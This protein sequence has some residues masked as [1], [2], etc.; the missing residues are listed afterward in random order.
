M[1]FLS[2]PFEFCESSL[3]FVAAMYFFSTFLPLILL[4]TPVQSASDSIRRHYEAAESHSR[5]GNL[6][7]A[8]AEYTAILAEAHH[9]LGRIQIARAEYSQAVATLQ[10]AASY[11]SD[12]TEVLVDLAIA[13]FH[14]EKY[15]R[16][17]DPLTAALARDGRN[18]PAHHMMG[19]THFMLGDFEGSARS[20]EAG[21]KL[22]PDDYDI[23]YTLGLAYLKQGQLPPAVKLYSR[24]IARLGD[25]P[26]LRVLIGRAYRETGYLGEAIEEFKRAIALDP[27]FPRVHYYLGLT[28]LLKD[29]AGR[30]GDAAAQFEIELAAHPDEYLA[31]YYLG[32]VNTIERN[33]DKALGF[34]NKAAQIQPA[35]P[36]P[37]FYLGQAFQSL[38]NYPQ[39]IEN[40]RKSIA[41]NPSLRHN[42]NQVTNAHYRLGQ[43]LLKVG[44]VAE[45]ERE[46]QLAAELKSKAFKRDEAK[47]ESFLNAAKLSEANKTSEL[48]SPGGVLAET[49]APDAQASEKLK[50]EAALYAKVIATAH[51]NIGLLRADLK[52]FRGAAAQFSRVAKL[53][54]EQ[55]D[56]D[57]NLGLAHFKSESFKDAVPPLENVLK[58]QPTNISAKHLL[59]MSYFMME[60]YTG[61]AKMLSDVIAAKPNE[62][63]LYFPLALSLGKLGKTEDAS[64]VT[65]QM[66]AI[67]GDSPQLR[68]M[69]GQAYYEQGQSAKALEELKAAVKLNSTVRLAHFY[70]G[71][72]YLKTGKFDEAIQE[73]ESELALNPADLQAK[74]HLGYVFLARQDPQRGIKLMREVIDAKPDFGNARFELG[75]AL[76][77]QGDIK[78]AVESLE[79]A[80]KLEPNQSHVHYQLGR[81]Y[82][83]AGRRTEGEREIEISK[84]IKEKARTQANP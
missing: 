12:S 36:D 74:Y 56:L 76:L 19:K 71:V 82:I 7:A 49:Y 52:D 27:R 54:P 25:R 53:N 59:G 3:E 84:G 47:T 70:A 46:L 5:A 73:F 8:E 26:Q 24:M 57:Y 20:L 31:N 34:M 48:V 66:M 68:I 43:S 33:W 9:R 51:N 38:E 75:K 50:T 23:A 81:A 32:I 42:D 63:A 10:T 18:V 13:Y 6:T 77:Q 16:A 55:Q 2:P 72:I 17:I 1:T 61:A 83:A 29:G 62:V 14:M 15:K 79:I 30:L 60:N 28:F 67:G 58:A 64:R 41:L 45:G 78:G 37:Y 69:L 44:Q 22:A 11:R 35:N 21:L 80:V 40:F 4:L 65:Q 39:A